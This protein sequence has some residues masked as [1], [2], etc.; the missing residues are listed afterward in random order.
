MSDQ[1][2]TID[3][4]AH[5]LPHPDQRQRFWRDVNLTTLDQLPDVLQQWQRVAEET[6]NAQAQAEQLREYAEQHDGQLPAD[7]RETPESRAAWNEWERQMRQQQGH[8]AA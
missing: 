6:R 1:P 2:W 4:I 7:Y 3:T 5:A 8:D